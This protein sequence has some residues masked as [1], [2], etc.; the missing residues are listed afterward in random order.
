[1]K[2]LVFIIL[3]ITVCDLFAVEQRYFCPDATEE[4][5]A[6]CY[7]VYGSAYVLDSCTCVFDRPELKCP[8]GA[9]PSS[10]TSCAHVRKSES[11]APEIIRDRRKRPGNTDCLPKVEVSR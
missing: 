11:A 6:R 4:V 1:M 7:P 3:S 9:E 10:N 5:E 8:L 2:K